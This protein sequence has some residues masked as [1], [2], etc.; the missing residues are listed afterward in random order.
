M[1]DHVNTQI[2]MIYLSYSTC[3]DLSPLFCLPVYGKKEKL[4]KAFFV[5]NVC[6]NE[7]SQ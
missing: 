4:H 7:G 5:I 1:Q 3:V 2:T 6:C